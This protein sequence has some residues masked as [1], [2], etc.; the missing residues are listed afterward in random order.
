MQGE[1]SIV[2]DDADVGFEIVRHGDLPT[3]SLPHPLGMFRT[4]WW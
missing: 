2:V 3:V 1:R 4:E